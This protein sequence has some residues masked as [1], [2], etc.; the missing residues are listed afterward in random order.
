MTWEREGNLV[1]LFFPTPSPRFS[2]RAKSRCAPIVKMG[3]C[4]ISG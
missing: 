3:T 2:S 4:E 1:K